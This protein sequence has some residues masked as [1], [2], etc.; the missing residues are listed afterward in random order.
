MPEPQKFLIRERVR[1]R[2]FLRTLARIRLKSDWSLD[3]QPHHGIPPMTKPQFMKRWKSRMGPNWREDMT[4]ELEA[5]GSTIDLLTQRDARVAVVLL[6]TGSWSRELPYHEPFA[7]RIAALCARKSVP[8]TDLTDALDEKDFVAFDN[9]HENYAG[10]LKCH[11][12][13]MKIARAHLR[14]I[15]AL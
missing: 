3:L 7:A 8:L 11:E 15:G 4:A 13:I 1:A 6:P 9:L 14:R 10:T 2:A 5:L 12:L